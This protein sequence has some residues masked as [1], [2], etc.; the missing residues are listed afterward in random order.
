M[1]NTKGAARGIAQTLRRFFINIFTSGKYKKSGEFGLSDSVI[2]YGLLNYM[3]IG[4]ITGIGALVAAIGWQW[5]FFSRLVCYCFIFISF[6]LVLLARTKIRLNIIST[7]YIIALSLYAVIHTWDGKAQGANFIYVFA[8]PLAS[9][10]LLGMA[11]GVIITV[12]DGVIIFLQMS[13][14]CLSKFD[15]DFDYAVRIILGYYIVSSMMIAIELTRKSKDRKIEAQRKQLDELNRAKSEFLATMSHEM[16][17]PLTVISL[18]IQR[19]AELVSVLGRPAEYDEKIIFSLRRAQEEIMRVSRMIENAMRFSSTKKISPK[20]G[21]LNISALLKT[22]AEIYR[23]LLEN[24][25]NR[26]AVN[27]ADNLPPVYGNTDLLVQVMANLLSNSNNHTNGGEIGIK[28]E[29]ENGENIAVTVTDNGA[30]ISPE[31]LPYMFERDVPGAN[32]MGIGL[33]ICKEII[34]SHNGTIQIES[35]TGKGTTVVFRIPLN[36]DLESRKG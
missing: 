9:V 33:S 26:L 2:Q 34:A 13:I 31:L 12:T 36:Q 25:G 14:P 24:G 30:G 23:P 28:A 20:M 32:G 22:T 3:L 18:H 27:I 19:A 7:I 6:V 16:K 5:S 35:E 4:G 10:L 29:T 17:T 11:R 1:Q 15:Y 8:I 21:P